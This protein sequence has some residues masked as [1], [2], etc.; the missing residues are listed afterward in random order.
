MSCTVCTHLNDNSVAFIKKQNEVRSS[1]SSEAIEID[2]SNPKACLLMSGKGTT[3]LSIYLLM[4]SAF[5]Q[6][7]VLYQMSQPT[8]TKTGGW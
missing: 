4:V 5:N 7:F 1:L 8:G 2:P 3:T 6:W